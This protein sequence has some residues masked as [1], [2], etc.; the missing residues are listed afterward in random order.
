MSISWART[1]HQERGWYIDSEA[2]YLTGEGKPSIHLFQLHL[3]RGSG[4]I[5]TLS[6][7][8]WEKL[9]NFRKRARTLLFLS[10]EA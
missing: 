2:P 5:D 9:E 6:S 3:G 8:V 7:T 10:K 4:G 1:D